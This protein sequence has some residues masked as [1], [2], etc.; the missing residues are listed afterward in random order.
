MH[1]RYG[2][3]AESVKNL[4]S[5]SASLGEVV[6]II[7][8]AGV[9]PANTSASEIISINAVGTVNMV[10]A[11]YPVIV[12]SGVMI[13]IASIAGHTLPL[14]KEITEIY[15]AYNMPDFFDKMLEVVKDWTNGADEFVVAGIAYSL[16]KN[17]VLYFTKMN[18]ARFFTK[19]CRII[20]ISPGSFLTP[21]HQSLIDNQP[22]MAESQLMEIPFKS[23]GH[24][25]EFGALVDFLCR[26]GVNFINGIDI[27]ID[28]GQSSNVTVKQI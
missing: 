4:A 16:S 5:Y 13:N 12:D 28:G 24:P 2:S 1:N 21:M 20:S 19:N 26:G 17:F 7:H 10:E 15:K 22:D 14:N 9:S 3:D 8:A 23:W 11:F 6:N 18:V 27:L 25:Y